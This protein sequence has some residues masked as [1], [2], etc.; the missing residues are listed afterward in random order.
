MSTATAT[1]Q[2]V[3]S[4]ITDLLAD[5]TALQQEG[6]DKLAQANEKFAQIRDLAN[7]QSGD[8]QVEG[9]SQPTAAAPAASRPAPKRSAAKKTSNAAPAAKRA[10]KKTAKKKD[11]PVAPTDRN[12]DNELTLKEAIWDALDRDGW[13]ELEMVP[14]DAEGLK[15]GEIKTLL[16]MEGKWTS[17]SANPGNQISAAISDLKKAGKIALGDGRRYY[18]VAGAEL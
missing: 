1:P 8:Y 6:R 4:E 13:P 14:E 5:A 10:K 3:S 17:A 7:Q 18:I 15:P 2:D 16:E 11:G 12:Y 9:D